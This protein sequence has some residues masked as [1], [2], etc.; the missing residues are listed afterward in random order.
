MVSNQLLPSPKNVSLSNEEGPK[1]KC[2]AI[3]IF[4]HLSSQDG[5]SW[6]FEDAEWASE[7]CFVYSCTFLEAGIDNT[8]PGK[9]DTK[10]WF[11]LADYACVQALAVTGNQAHENKGPLCY[12]HMHQFRYQADLSTHYMGGSEK[13]GRSFFYT[14]S[15]IYL[16]APPP[17]A[18]A[19]HIYRG[20]SDHHRIN[21]KRGSSFKYIAFP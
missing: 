1:N 6:C 12:K 20:H 17:R 3:R 10:I 18:Y 5:N 14:N 21:R 13:W 11:S 7:K 4:L 19:P 9:L 2:S 15:S 8:N 16:V